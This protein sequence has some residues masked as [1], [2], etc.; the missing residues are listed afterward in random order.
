MPVR[1]VTREAKRTE[2]RKAARARPV[3]RDSSESEDSD[4]GGSKDGV[5]GHIVVSSVRI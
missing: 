2:C 4:D 1:T 5:R 3:H